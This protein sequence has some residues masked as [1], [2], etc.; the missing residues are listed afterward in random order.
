MPD[1]L[2][3]A[4]EKLRPANYPR[5]DKHHTAWYPSLPVLLTAWVARGSLPFQ[6]LQLFCA[7]FESTLDMPPPITTQALKLP[8]E[9]PI[10]D[11][12]ETDE[13]MAQVSH[14]KARDHS[15]VDVRPHGSRDGG[16]TPDGAPP[17]L[18]GFLTCLNAVDDKPVAGLVR[19]FHLAR[20]LAGCDV[21][22]FPHDS[23]RRQW[24]RAHVAPDSKLVLMG[25][26]FSVQSRVVRR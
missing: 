7:Q 15:S 6:D 22:S 14:L 18:N 11:L 16:H 10:V 8:P 23:L 1:T 20:Q 2:Q 17:V 21:P 4:L 25:G 5:I 13:Q 19:A 24:L 3:S 26:G 12:T 9:S